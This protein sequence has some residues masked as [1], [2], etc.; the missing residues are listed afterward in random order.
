MPAGYMQL[1]ELRSVAPAPLRPVIKGILSAS[2]CVVDIPYNFT[3]IVNVVRIDDV[4]IIDG[5]GHKIQFDG[6]HC[7]W[8]PGDKGVLKFTCTTVVNTTYYPPGVVNATRKGRARKGRIVRIN[9]VKSGQS[10]SILSL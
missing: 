5:S 6:A 9:D 2:V 3:R 7:R 8:V 10:S 4:G 1:N